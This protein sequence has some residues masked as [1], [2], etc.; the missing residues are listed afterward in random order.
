MGT[1]L[2]IFVK[3]PYA[4]FLA[5][6][7]LFLIA[8]LFSYLRWYDKEIT[9]RMRDHEAVRRERESA[10]RSEARIDGHAAKL[11]DG[12]PLNRNADELEIVFTDGPH[13][14]KRADPTGTVIAYEWREPLTRDAH[15]KSRG[16]AVY[17][18]CYKLDRYEGVENGKTPNA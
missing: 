14:G 16:Y 11:S 12:L 10:K 15:G 4:T 9:L 2:E 18:L 17:R 1:L 7:S 6:A 8:K 5:V 13:Q 3:H